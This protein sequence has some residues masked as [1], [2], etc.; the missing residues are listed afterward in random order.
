MSLALSP[1]RLVL[2]DALTT[3]RS[4]AGDLVLTLAGTAALTTAMR[5]GLDAGRGAPLLWRAVLS[6]DERA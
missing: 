2:V 1:R 6:V 4:R 5:I 3:D